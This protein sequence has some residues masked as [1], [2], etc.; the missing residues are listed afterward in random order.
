MTTVVPENLPAAKR[1][2]P[3]DAQHSNH[4]VISDRLQ[5]QLRLLTPHHP[6]LRCL[7]YIQTP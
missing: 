2:V 5:S 4:S 3:I 7:H 6:L 1:V